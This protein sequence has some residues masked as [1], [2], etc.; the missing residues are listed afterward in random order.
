MFV[1]IIILSFMQC[2][3]YNFSDFNTVRECKNK[4]LPVQSL[5]LEDQRLKNELQDLDIASFL[6]TLPIG[7]KRMNLLKP[8]ISYQ[9]FTNILANTLKIS[10]FRNQETHLQELSKDDFFEKAVLFDENA[11]VHVVGDQ[12]AS[13][14]DTVEF[15]SSI[16]CS[17]TPLAESP[18]VENSL[19][20]KEK[21]KN[22]HWIF[23]GDLTDSGIYGVETLAVIFS[24]HLTNPFNIHIIRGNHEDV[25]INNRY[26]FLQEIKEKYKD[27]LED[28]KMQKLEVIRNLLI[29][30]Y[31]QLPVALWGIFKSTNKN[32]MSVTLFCHGGIEFDD[33][34]LI[35][36]FDEC[37]KKA[38]SYKKVEGEFN[39]DPF[40]IGYL[41]NDFEPNNKIIESNLIEGRGYRISEK[42]FQEWIKD[43]FKNQKTFIFTHM[44]RAHQHSTTYAELMPTLIQNNGICQLWDH[45]NPLVATLCVMP[46]TGFGIPY[47]TKLHTYPG[48]IQNTKVTIYYDNKKNL[49]MYDF[50]TLPNNHIPKDIIDMHKKYKNELNGLVNS[51]MPKTYNL[52]KTKKIAEQKE[53]AH[54][55]HT[56][57]LEKSSSFYKWLKTSFKKQVNTIK[58]W[59]RLK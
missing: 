53:S 58:S 50:V 28:K 13:F 8:M 19:K 27:K 30:V 56:Y 25:R 35:P 7:L 12:H 46:C 26:G 38:V 52:V 33:K 44:F 21:F 23:C 22:H 10:F 11:I 37:V 31:H 18:F 48:I 51:T 36:F 42:D 9:Q 17:K 15:L 1:F 40:K 59:F 24:V 4:F 57:K 3:T 14:H 32:Q 47:K 49:F 41:W 20:L 55:I 6:K 39:G 16:F 43:N 2:T 54:I 34:N 45:N 5:F 29:T